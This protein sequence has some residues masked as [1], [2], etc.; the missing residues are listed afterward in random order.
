TLV[1]ITS[2]EI[3]QLEASSKDGPQASDDM[4]GE[5]DG[6]ALT[7][8]AAKPLTRYSSRDSVPGTEKGPE[9]I[10]L[11]PLL[12]SV[13]SNPMSIHIEFKSREPDSKVNMG[14]LKLIYKKLWG[15]DITDRVV[16]YVDGD[17]IN[18][19]KV[20]LPEGT[21]TLEIYIEDS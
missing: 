20:E 1:L 17:A 5:S 6:G 14:S 4:T 19:P 11:Q 15:I 3:A 10:I 13:V 21:H 2:E 9:I 12:T 7:I 16:E 18:A 8:S